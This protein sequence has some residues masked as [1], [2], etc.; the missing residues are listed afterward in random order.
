MTQP[1]PRA[2]LGVAAVL[3]LADQAS[4]LAVDA[5]MRLGESI[6]LLPNIYLTYVLNPGGAFSLFAGAPDWIRR[7]LFLLVPLAALWV[8]WAYWKSLPAGDRLSEIALG[9]VVGG[10]LGNLVDRARLGQ[11]IDFAHVDIPT[12]LLF[13]WM[14]DWVPHLYTWPIFNVADSAV[15]IG[16][17]LLA[18]RTFRPL[19]THASHP[20]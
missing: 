19:E 10:A 17:G 1:L 12:G 5:T 3:L 8:A 4:K 9:L 13:G 6:P 7:P 2:G 16:I 18:W 20:V 11:V 14:G 15:L